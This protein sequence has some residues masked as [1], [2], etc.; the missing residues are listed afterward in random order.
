VKY[1]TIRGIIGI[2]TSMNWEIQQLDVKTAFLYGHL[3]ET[4]YMEL[5]CLPP[6]IDLGGINGNCLQL[7][8]SIYGLKQASRAWNETFHQFIMSIN[9]EVSKYDPC[10]YYRKKSLIIIYLLLYVDDVILTGNCLRELEII[11]KQL[12]SK[13][14]MSDLGKCQ[15]VLGIELIES[16]TSRSL[17]QQRYI[18]DILNRFEMQDCKPAS[19]PINISEKIT[20]H[21]CPKTNEEILDMKNIPYREA[22][23]SL[24]HLMVSSRPDLAYAVGYVARFMENPGK[25]HWIAVKRIMRY[26]KG[27]KDYA[28]TFKKNVPLKL[29]GYSDAD[30]AGNLD[31]RKSTSGYLFKIAQGTISWG[32][33]K[34]NCV[35]LST[36][37][38]EYIAL[39]LAIQEGTWINNLFNEIIGEKLVENQLI[40]FEDNQ[41]CI[42]MSKNPINHGRAK[43]IDI[44][45][46]FIRDCVKS[47]HVKLLYKETK[48][49]LADIL[50]K[51]LPGPRHLE[52]LEQLGLQRSS[53]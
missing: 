52:L 41:S 17:S 47:G 22:V 12:Q 15:F 4:I 48:F 25:V 53:H 24:M 29:E 34:Q 28:I 18:N 43:H 50:T 26:L 35:A 3:D 49:M 5:P 40:I 14:Q 51:G 38:A 21:Q 13:F 10:L 31:D 36:S 19:T 7:K 2:A 9:F 11:K 37:E 20:L 33:K 6:S 8:K 45:Y 30:W 32:S 46:H 39:S 1:V 44:K 23:G 42:K 16:E 27:T